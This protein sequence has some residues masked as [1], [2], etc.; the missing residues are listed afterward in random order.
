MARGL[1]VTATDT[2]VGKTVVAAA[3]VAVG[4]R[5]GPV[6]YWKPV[7][8][9]IEQDDDTAEVA[10]L[11][12]CAPDEI[13]AAGVRLPRP[14][15]PHLAARHAGVSIT[16]DAVLD[17]GRSAPR[18]RT[19]ESFWIVEGAGGVLVPLNDR[20]KIV[21]LMA[22]L[23]LPAV[24]VARTS[25]G[26]INHTLLTVEALRRRGLEV[27]FVVLSGPPDEDARRA[28]EEYGSVRVEELPPIVPLEPAA[29][30]AWAE[31][32]GAAWPI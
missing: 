22:R 7:Q 32:G 19:T 2:G 16:V 4:R 29:L 15:S 18:V 31:T 8:T 11:A 23:A 10:R 21:D 17:I 30:S 28:I 14:V 13:V 27:A 20:E 26:T 1:F 25:V 12:D 3:L 9:G 5:R 6:R 24:V